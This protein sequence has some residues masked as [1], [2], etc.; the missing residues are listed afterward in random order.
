M[1]DEGIFSGPLPKGMQLPVPE[2]DVFDQAAESVLSSSDVNYAKLIR[3][4][5]GSV[6]EVDLVVSGLGTSEALGAHPVVQLEVI[7]M[8][9]AES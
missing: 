5:L 3:D 1:S 4:A 8:P 9:R 7:V 6:T 2:V